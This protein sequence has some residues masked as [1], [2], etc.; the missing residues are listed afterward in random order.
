VIEKG[1]ISQTHNGYNITHKNYIVGLNQ[2]WNENR[3]RIG[4]NKW[5]VTAFDDSLEKATSKAPV[6]SFDGKNAAFANSDEIIP[7]VDK[8]LANAHIGS[9]L[10]SGVL[11]SKDE[12]GEFNPENFVKGFLYGAFGSKVAGVA[13]G[14]LS[15]KLYNKFLGLSQQFPQM[16]KGNPKLLGKIYAKA[17]DSSINSFAGQRALT[18]NKAR[19]SEAL[20]MVKNGVD[21]ATIWQKTGW[22]KD[23]LDDKWKF[24]I[25]PKGGQIINKDAKSLGEFLKDDELFSAYP[26]LKDIRVLKLDDVSDNAMM[27][28]KDAT[29]KQKRGIYNVTHNNKKATYIKQDLQSVENALRY[30][31]GDKSKGAEHIKIRHMSDS[32]RFGYVSNDELLNL[33]ESIRKYVTK[34]GEPFIDDKGGRVYEWADKDGVRF[35]LV[36]YEKR[37]GVGS[38]PDITSTSPYESIITFYSDRN[39]KKPMEFKNPKVAYEIANS[40]PTEFLKQKYL[41]WAKQKEKRGIYNVAFNDKKSTIIYKDLENIEQIIKFEKGKTD[42]IK[43]GELKSGYGALHIQKHLN[44]NADGWVTSQEYLNMGQMLRKATMQEVKNKRVYTYFDDNNV[45]FRII[46]G[47]NKNNERV[48]S[49]YSN[50]KAGLNYNSQNYDDNLPKKEILEQNSLKFNKDSEREI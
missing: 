31:K 34:Y 13:I 6:D 30:A 37:A 45:R 42:Q 15:P 4:N 39:I 32:K 22:F 23:E 50:R 10:I 33:G 46:V 12:N 14:K 7:Q 47:N 49:F 11:N 48:I 2:G 41:E 3:V 19:L 27:S 35:R 9:G 17:P 8:I 1:E 16:A 21:E 25:N 26:E 29:Q 44:K 20:K 18:A 28:V 24:E 43:K 40:K 36:V 5:I 38:T